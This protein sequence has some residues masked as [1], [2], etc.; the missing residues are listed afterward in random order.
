MRIH[1]RDRRRQPDSG[2][3]RGDAALFFTMTEPQPVIGEGVGNLPADAE[4]RVQRIH[5]AL[6]HERNAGKAQSAD[7]VI[8]EIGDA[9]IRTLP[10]G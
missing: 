6:R 3:E 2:E 5:R 10:S 7:A 1:A 8:V 9:G 4:D